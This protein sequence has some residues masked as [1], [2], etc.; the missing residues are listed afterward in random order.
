MKFLLNGLSNL[1]TKYPIVVLVFVV[2]L[3]GFFGSLGAP[4]QESGFENFS[5][6]SKEIDAFARSG[7]C[8][9]IFYPQLKKV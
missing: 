5:P 2:V 1:S 4:V 8:E 9:S 7:G 6:D 3:S